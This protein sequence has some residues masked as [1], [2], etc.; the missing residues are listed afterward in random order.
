MKKLIIIVLLLQISQQIFANNEDCIRCHKSNTLSVIDFETGVIKS[1][2]VEIDKFNNSNHKNLKCSFCHTNG[3]DKWPHIDSNSITMNCVNCHSGNSAFLNKNPEIKTRVK[4]L[5][6]NIIFTEF[7][8]S[9]HFVKYGDKFTCFSCHNP[10]S[11]SKEQDSIKLKIKNNND[12]CLKC[13][14]SEHPEGVLHNISM[15][16]LELSH[17][18]LPNPKLHWQSVRCI[19]CH[20]SENN[21]HMSHKILAK[22]EAVK[23]CESCHSENSALL[24]KL[25]KHTHKESVQKNGF[26]NGTLLS[27][28]YVIG[29][30]RNAILDRMSLI[31]FVSIIAGIFTHSFFRWK[32]K[33]NKNNLK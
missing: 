24:S 22:E 10:H 13:H 31:L 6:V 21:N 25:Y 32:T 14:N 5:E 11:F 19:D 1:F 2:H 8:N 9:V 18:W 12:M 20:I 27:D 17:N 26:I 28:A 16:S 3:Y 7:K 30:T 33:K 15:P 4:E 29:S 23:K